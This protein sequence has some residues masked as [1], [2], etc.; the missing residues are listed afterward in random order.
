MFPCSVRLTNLHLAL[1]NKRVA[2]TT[3]I[4]K[5]I[6]SVSLV[7]SVAQKPGIYSCRF[8]CGFSTYAL[9]QV[10]C[11]DLDCGEEG[12]WMADELETCA[13]AKL[14]EMKVVRDRYL[15]DIASW[16]AP[17]MPAG[18]ALFV[19]QRSCGG[20]GHCAEMK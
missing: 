8:D 5:I 10:L 3:M 17:A 20:I 2:G 12:V 9:Q 15:I 11:P 14:G 16:A 7:L 18:L 13:F 4:S 6:Q 1:K 19:L